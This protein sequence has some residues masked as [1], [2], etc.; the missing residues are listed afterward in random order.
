MREMTNY[1][2]SLTGATGKALEPETVTVGPKQ[3]IKIAEDVTPKPE[4][5]VKGSSKSKKETTPA[6]VSHG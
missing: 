3:L 5:V 1:A 4:K 6:E 2:A